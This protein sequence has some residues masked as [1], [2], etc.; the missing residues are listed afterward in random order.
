MAWTLLQRDV[1][2]SI[3]IEDSE[4]YC[5]FVPERVAEIVG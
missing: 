5:E 4:Q 2:D 1:R 3:G